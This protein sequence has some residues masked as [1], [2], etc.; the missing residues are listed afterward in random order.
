MPGIQWI[1][2]YSSS[3]LMLICGQYYYAYFIDRKA[4]GWEVDKSKI[5]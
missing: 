4:E 2:F 1:I 3:Y 5:I